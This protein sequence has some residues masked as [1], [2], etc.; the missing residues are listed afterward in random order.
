VK[1]DLRG[2]SFSDVEAVLELGEG[3]ECHLQKD[4]ILR[5]EGGV[6]FLKEEARPKIEYEK[7]W[8]GR[9]ILEIKELSLKF[10]GKKRKNSNSLPLEVDDEREAFLDGEKLKFP[11]LVR[12]RKQGDKYQPLGAPGKKKLKEIMRAKR[13]PLS[14]REKRPVF[15]GENDIVWVVGLPVS[16][17]YKVKKNTNVIFMIRKL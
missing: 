3:K 14:D 4:L 10:E 6:V 11:L 9:S 12:N 13:I 16:E 7:V 2:I 8:N 5:R 1:G 17:S 15:L